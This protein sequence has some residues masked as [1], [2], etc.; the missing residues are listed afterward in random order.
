MR[1]SLIQQHAS[2]DVGE[3]TE[4]GLSA[5]REAAAAGAK[6]VV[7]PEVAFHRF[8]PQ[9]PRGRRPEPEAEGVPGPTTDRFAMLAREL[10]V[11]VVLNLFE[12]DGEKTYDA[13]PVI[14]AGGKVL[15]CTRMVHVMDGPCWHE[16][17][18]YHP[19]DRGA[20]VY[21]TAAGRIGVAICYDRHFPEY[22][23]A[24]ALKGADLVVVPQAGAVDEWPEGLFEAEMRVAAFQNGCFVALANRVGA[25]ERLTFAGESF[26]A[27]PFGR[28]IA[29]APRGEDAI[30]YAEIDYGLLAD[31]AAR[32]HFLR[33]R[34]P[35]IY[36]L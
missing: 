14:D 15:G 26:V 6:L 2:H 10:G 12:R 34:R 17:G 25:E 4:R 18:Y 27:D 13:S 11:V 22:T 7:Y 9:H 31:C 1:I 30:L 24:L 19:G 35:E 5:L 29:R 33:D 32:R 8:F 20:P 3:N 28:V 36:P 23:R 16:T 21:E